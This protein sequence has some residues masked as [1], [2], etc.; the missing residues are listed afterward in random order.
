MHYAFLGLPLGLLLID[1]G[2]SLFGVLLVAVVLVS[3][4]R[5]AAGR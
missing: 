2:Q 1:M 3:W 4:P 5:R